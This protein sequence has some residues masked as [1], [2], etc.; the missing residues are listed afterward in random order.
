MRKGESRELQLILF[1]LGDEVYSVELEKIR[2]VINAR[3][4]LRLPRAAASV[5]GVMN[6][7]GKVVPL[8]DLASYLGVEGGDK[9]KILIYSS[10]GRELGFLVT[11]I[12]GVVRVCKDDVRGGEYGRVSPVI[13]GFIVRKGSLVPVLDLDRIAHE[14][15][16][17]LGESR[18]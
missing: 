16:E 9:S 13:K 12:M 18:G 1:K 2:E 6:L 15:L 8:I 10:N 4:V 17:S 7:R 3:N 5:E 14:V 11:H